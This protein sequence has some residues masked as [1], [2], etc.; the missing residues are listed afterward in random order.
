MID[1]EFKVI[2]GMWTKKRLFV[3]K[4]TDECMIVEWKENVEYAWKETI[5]SKLKGIVNWNVLDV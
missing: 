1:W 5:D 2:V 3:Y 4:L